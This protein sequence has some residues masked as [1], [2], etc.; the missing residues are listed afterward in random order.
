MTSKL[1]KALCLTCG[2]IVFSQVGHTAVTKTTETKM[3]NSVVKITPIEKALQQQK[4]DRKFHS[5]D[6]LKV[7]TSINIAP[8]QSFLASQNERFS[9]FI[10]TLF[11]TNNS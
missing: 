2:L 8:S 6:N 7:L 1:F 9:H 11:T 10:Q 3:V 4:N 5:E